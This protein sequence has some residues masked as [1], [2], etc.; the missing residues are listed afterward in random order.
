MELPA[1]TSAGVSRA[2]GER[3]KIL[4]K[5]SGTRSR[6]GSSPRPEL[7]AKNALEKLLLLY[8]QDFKE[9]HL[10]SLQRRFRAWKQEHGLLGKAVF[11]EQIH[12][13]GRLLQLDWFHPRDF[14]VTLGGE[15]YKH[16]ICHTVLTYSN[17]EWALPCRSESFASLRATLQASLWEAGGV[18]QVCQVDNS[19]TA[20]HQLGKGS[21]GRGFNDRFLGLVAHYGMRAQ[22]I[23]VG[24]AHENGDVESSHS[25]LRRYLADA[26]ELRGSSDFENLRQYQDWLE[27]CLRRRNQ[28]REEKFSEECKGLSPLPA[29]KLPEFEEMDCRVNKYCLVR[30]G[31]GSYSV[32]SKYRTRSLRARIYESRIELWCEEKL[33]AAFERGAN[34]GG[35]CVDWRHLIEELCRKPGAFGRYRYR[36]YF[37]PSLLWRQVN[38]QLRERF[39]EARADSDYLQILKLAHE[40]GQERVEELLLRFKDTPELTLDR[41]RRDLGEQKQWRADS[42]E[43][44]PDLKAYDCL[45]SREVSHG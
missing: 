14:E 8:P 44:K 4:L 35:A 11:F 12:H 24:A 29:C 16:L 42:R 32:P 26:L 17:W 3:V 33:V 21:R 7:Q 9:G 5:R 13:P 22:T 38:D 15:V 18:A 37:Y 39:S 31:K 1:P 28:R 23:Q 2:T 45:L 10:R 36:E 27:Q 40:N 30:V 6:V 41:I 34:A 25:H 43:I 20:T 19:S